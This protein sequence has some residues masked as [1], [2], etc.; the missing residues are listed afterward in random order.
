MGTNNKKKQSWNDSF[1]SF[2][3]VDEQ[4]PV[5][6]SKKQNQNVAKNKSKKEDK[7]KD[8]EENNKDSE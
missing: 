5:K 6:G 1:V 3:G 2:M 4:L 7:D 8:K